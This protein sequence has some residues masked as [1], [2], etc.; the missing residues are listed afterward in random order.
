MTELCN[1]LHTIADAVFGRF[2]EWFSGEGIRLGREAENGTVS[3][4]LCLGAVF[5]A[6]PGYTLVGGYVNGTE[7]ISGSFSVSLR[8]KDG[9]T[10]SRVSAERILARLC[11]FVRGEMWEESISSSVQLRALRPSSL[12]A[13]MRLIPGGGAVWE[14]SLRFTAL[15]RRG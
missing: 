10:A 1:D 15:I 8:M 9:D 2:A 5:R 11:G 12:P 7:V 13:R 4:S 14:L 3:G 6:E